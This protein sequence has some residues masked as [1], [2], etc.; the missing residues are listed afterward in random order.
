MKRFLKELLCWHEWENALQYRKCR[1][2]TYCV[3]C[4]KAKSIF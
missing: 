2:F 4:E 1:G 3:K